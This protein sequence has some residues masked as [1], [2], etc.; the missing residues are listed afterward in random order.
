MWSLA[1]TVF[2]LVTGDFLFEPKRGKSFT[3]NEDH[4]ALINELIGD[5]S[6]KKFLLSG[7]RSERFFDKNG[8]LKNIKKLKFWKLYDVLIEKYRLRDLEAKGLA[9]FLLKMLKWDPKDRAS[10]SEMLNHYWLK[11]IPNY[12]TKMGRMECREY[13][14]ANNYS[15]SASKDSNL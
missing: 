6:N 9:D 7:S 15:V 13:K 2:E 14:K 12:N 3:K 4:L 10:A 11:M 5:C 8:K 1:C